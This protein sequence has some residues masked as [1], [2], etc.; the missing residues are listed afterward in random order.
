MT[1]DVKTLIPPIANAPFDSQITAGAHPLS[2]TSFVASPTRIDGPQRSGEEVVRFLEKELNTRESTRNR[3]TDLR[4]VLARMEGVP[5]DEIAA[6]FGTSPQKL[7]AWL[8]GSSTVPAK[9]ADLIH[10]LNLL[11]MRLSRVLDP[12]ALP[13]WLATPNGKLAGRTPFEA[14]KRGKVREVLEVVD[15]YLEPTFG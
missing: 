9:K 8:H 10:D 6:I 3:A 12:T 15:S 13:R 4:V 2:P 7:A 14:L 11:V 5:F 1:S